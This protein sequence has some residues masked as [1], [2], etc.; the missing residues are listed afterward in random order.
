M[1][2]LHS[3]EIMLLKQE[4]SV[5]VV[6][7]KIVLTSVVLDEILMETD[8]HLRQGPVA[9]NFDSLVSDF[10]LNPN[11]LDRQHLCYVYQLYRI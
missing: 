3:V 5:T 10:F 6:M 4:N 7:L 1:T 8:V 2:M 9:G 11:I